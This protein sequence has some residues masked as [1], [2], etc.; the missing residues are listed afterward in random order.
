MHTLHALALLRLAAGQSVAS[1]HVLSLLTTIVKRMCDE[2]RATPSDVQ[3]C[4][5]AMRF[6]SALAE[7]GHRLSPPEA[8]PWGVLEGEALRRHQDPLGALQRGEVPAIMLRGFL[9][10]DELHI[11][12]TRMAQLTVRIF[13]CRYSENITGAAFSAGGS[14]R[15]L[16]KISNDTDCLDLNRRSATADLA[17][18]H[19][20]TLLA[21]VEHDCNHRAEV[22]RVPECVLLRSHHPVFDRCR[23]DQGRRPRRTTFTR[24]RQDKVVRSAA[25]EFGSKLYGNLFPAAKSRFMRSA[26]A[27]DALHEL[28]A[29]GCKGRFCSPK[30]AML[31]GVAELAGSLRTTRQAEEGPGEKHS[32][33]TVRA[34]TNGWITPLHMDSK[35]SN[36]FAALRKEICGDAVTLSLRTSPAEAARFQALTRHRFAASAILTL[37]APNRTSNPIDLN[38]FRHRWPALLENCS[39]K[40]VD[41]YGVGVRFRRDSIPPPVLENPLTVTA[42]AGDLFLFNSEFFHDTPRILGASSRTV[43]NSFAGFSANGGAV[44]V[45]A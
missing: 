39:V 45:Y 44:E 6:Q 8:D 37:H 43:F 3:A 16:R 4:T 31:A 35:H 15:A 13:A 33:G 41:A 28:M 38:V 22:A 34:M 42:N 21:H 2:S 24:L 40:Y 26:G 29:R 12:L 20:C 18:P 25:R 32:P 30:N 27:I 23:H 10:E 1:E 11:M 36:A 19:W 14:A 17:W 5:D 7:S 9:P